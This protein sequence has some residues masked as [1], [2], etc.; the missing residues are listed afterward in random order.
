[1]GR[2]VLV[3]QARGRSGLGSFLQTPTLC[4]PARLGPDALA[5]AADI[6]GCGGTAG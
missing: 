6:A 4:L 5:T 1:M 3:T 2:W